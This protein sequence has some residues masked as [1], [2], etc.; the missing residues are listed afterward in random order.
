[1]F[2]CSSSKDLTSSDTPENMSTWNSLEDAILFLNF[3]VFGDSTYSPVRIE[4]TNSIIRDGRIKE[5]EYETFPHQPDDLVFIIFDS[6]NVAMKN[7]S[8]R[9]PLISH[10]EYVEDDGGLMTKKISMLE[11][12]HFL[13]IQ[14]R[15]GM[16]TLKM[17]TRNKM[18]LEGLIFLAEVQ[19][20]ALPNH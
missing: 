12:E 4:I 19:L 17:T 9:N 2:S 16:Q 13:R 6:K 11:K 7:I 20:M 10:M 1:M 15:P 3:K 14:L 18:E 5:A 8:I